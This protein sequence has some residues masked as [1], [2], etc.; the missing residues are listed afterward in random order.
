MHSHTILQ[1]VMYQSG[2]DCA[3]LHRRAPPDRAAMYQVWH[4]SNTVERSSC[5]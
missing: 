5:V 1:I 2:Y 4:R 3:R